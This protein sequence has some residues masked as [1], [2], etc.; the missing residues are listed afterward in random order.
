VE[1]QI[2]E[3]S[4]YYLIISF[5]TIT[6]TVILTFDSSYQ[7][8]MELI[9]SPFTMLFALSK[10]IKSCNK[11]M[12]DSNFMGLQHHLVFWV[13]CTILTLGKALLF[14]IIL[15][16]VT[17]SPTLILQSPLREVGMDNVKVRL[18]IF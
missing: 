16:Q 6:T 14:T 18:S 15:I 1:R 4:Q 13:N 5:V 3:M 12:P 7:T 2:V 11:H 9:A 10:S 17:S 8:S